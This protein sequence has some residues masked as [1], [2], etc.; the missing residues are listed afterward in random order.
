MTFPSRELSAR[1]RCSGGDR[2]LAVIGAAEACGVRVRDVLGPSKEASVSRARHI[3]AYLLRTHCLMSF[4]EV[5]RELGRRDHTTAM[6]SVRRV[7]SSAE[8]L[9]LADRAWTMAVGAAA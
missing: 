9:A 7:E 5:A 1:L 3:A 2:T 6:S 8:L 4:P